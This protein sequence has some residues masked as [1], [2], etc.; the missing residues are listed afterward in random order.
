MATTRQIAMVTAHV[1]GGPK[2]T[3]ALGGPAVDPAAQA[4]AMAAATLVG[5]TISALL[6]RADGSPGDCTADSDRC[7]T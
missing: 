3:V 1:E 2:V 4:V 6:R 5:T 7:P